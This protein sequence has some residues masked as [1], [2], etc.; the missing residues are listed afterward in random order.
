MSVGM[1]SKKTYSIK[2]AAVVGNQSVINAS[3]SQKYVQYPSSPEN[4]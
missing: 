2:I 1:C 3:G 4:L